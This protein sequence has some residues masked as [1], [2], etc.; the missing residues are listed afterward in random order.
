MRVLF[1][2][3]EA[4][5]FAATGG[6]GDVAGALP[7][8]LKKQE[9]NIS[10]VLPLYESIKENYQNQLTFLDSFYVSVG[11]RNQYSGVFEYHNKGV[12]YLFLDNEYYFNRTG[13]YGYY[14]DAERFAFFARATIEMMIHIDLAVDIIH[15]NDWQ[16]A[17][18]PVFLKL[19]YQQ[20][21]RFEQVKTVTTIH[22]IGYQG[23]FDPFIIGDVLG[24]DESNRNRL[25]Y[26][27]DANFLKSAVIE[28]DRIL[29]V[30]PTYATELLD[31]WYA[32]GL[33]GLLRQYSYKLTG[34]L[35]GID[36]T[37]FNPRTD[38]SIA[39][40]FS[41][42]DLSGKM[43]CK[44][45]LL[46]RFTLPDDGSPLIGI[47]SRLVAHKGFDLVCEVFDQLISSGYQV[48]VL[49]SGEARFEQTFNDFHMRYPDRFGLV[50]GYIPELSKQIY[51]GSD[52]FLMP[53][54]TEPC[55][56]S[57]MMALRYGSIPIV[58]ETGGLKDT[59]TDSGDDKG[60]GF[61]FQSYDAYDMLNACLR[62]K[63]TYE[64][65]ELWQQLILRAMKCKNGWGNAAGQYV[66][67]YEEMIANGT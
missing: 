5:P 60:N 55:G 40:N 50:L 35:N 28:S 21:K 52:M 2:A 67:F 1:A 8:A 10:V 20:Q 46:E 53:S 38:K 42:R 49:G 27:Y 65:S 48:V 37:I 19:F 57:Q 56:L 59:V 7:L 23:T 45:A 11:W 6:L 22:N 44:Q 18:V 4:V 51:A 26:N 34:I 36:T 63:D 64:D 43:L 3:S 30:S 33:D 66:K 29:T 17:L 41:L 12:R 31:P 14:D 16:T 47:V 9:V 58:R 62:A 61:T 39:A 15:L 24:I 54:R 32:Y 25:I 13:L